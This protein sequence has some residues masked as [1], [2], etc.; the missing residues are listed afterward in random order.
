[1]KLTDEIKRRFDYKYKVGE[2]PW[3]RP[4]IDDDIKSFL[5]TAK[6]EFNGG[7]ILDLG[8]GNGWLSVYFA[9]NGF[10]VKGVDSSPVAI[11]E[12]KN[13]AKK[14]N[15]SVEFKTGDA[16]DF[17]YP[18]QEFNIVI[19]RG[20]L[21]HVPKS[22]WGKYK[23]GISRVLKIGGLF[24]L[25]VFSDKSKKPGFNPKSGQMWR[26]VKEGSYLTYDHFFNK[27]LISDI[28][29]KDFEIIS[30]NQDPKAQPNGSRLLYFTLRKKA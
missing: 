29:D 15:I 11:K 26:K 8:C 10:K 1:M 2:T 18:D 12:A 23:K 20:L 5:K 25:M 13:T 27:K 4:V 9:K 24:Y 21:H 22:N 28:F 19:D 30:F 14:D 16:L 6:R 17:Q 3:V 7:K